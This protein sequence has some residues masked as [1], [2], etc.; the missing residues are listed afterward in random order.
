MNGRRRQT[1]ISLAGAYQA[2]HTGKLTTKPSPATTPWRPQEANTDT[3]FDSTLSAAVKP[4]ES[5]ALKE[6]RHYF[7]EGL[8]E[9]R[10]A[11]EAKAKKIVRESR[12]RMRLEGDPLGLTT[13]QY[14]KR[15]RISP[16]QPTPERVRQGKKV[17]EVLDRRALTSDKGEE[18]NV[19]VTEITPAIRALRQR[20]T[21]GDEEHQAAL[22]F[23][24]NVHGSRFTGSVTVRYQER[25]DGGGG[26]IYESD[27]VIANRQALR[28]AIRSVHPLLSPAL[29]W[30]IKSMGDPEPLSILGAY[31]APGRSA[32]TQSAR[33]A[34]VLCLALTE[35][36]EHYGIDHPLSRRARSEHLEAVLALIV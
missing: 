16:D 35:L 7:G 36:C 28:S 33:G 2:D 12:V 30:L 11:A 5:E 4:F 14:A 19:H 6:L 22:K 26:G 24:Q 10:A 15:P 23:L 34:G 1:T 29:A 31:Y 25:V 17:G 18:L 32:A 27:F 3:D 21:I 8:P 9:E 20:G 13:G